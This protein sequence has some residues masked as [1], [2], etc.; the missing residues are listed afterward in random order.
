LDF[1]EVFLFWIADPDLSTFLDLS[2]A[3]SVWV[4]GAEKLPVP[5]DFSG[6]VFR[7]VCTEGFSGS[8]GLLGV[9][10]L[11]CVNGFSAWPDFKGAACSDC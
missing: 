9:T 4:A 2:V 8:T 3:F 5:A 7:L 6:E 1:P 10:T 11:G